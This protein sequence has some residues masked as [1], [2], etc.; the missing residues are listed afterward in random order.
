MELYKK[1]VAKFLLSSEVIYVIPPYQRA[2]SWG[3][4]RWQGLA[5]DVL[6]KY[7]SPD[8]KHWIGIVVTAKSEMNI[9]RVDYTRRQYDLIDGQQRLITLRVWTQ[10]LLDHA[11]ERGE[12]LDEESLPFAQI[13]VQEI[14]KRDFEDV[15]GANNP[16]RQKWRTYGPDET[17][18]MHCYTYF[19]WILWLGSNA[20][21]KTEP[22]P[23][24]KKGRSQSEQNLTVEQQWQSTLDKRSRM[25]EEDESEVWIVQRGEQIPVAD[26]LKATLEYLNVFE[27]EREDSVD[28]EP[29]EIFEAL[30]GKRTQLDQF[31]H[32]KTFIFANVKDLES[33]YSLYEDDWKEFEIALERHTRKMRGAI[34]GDTFLY[35]YLISVGE[36]RYQSISMNRTA[37][38][39]TRYF[40]NRAS[41]SA[42]EI[43]RNDFLKSMRAWIA[44][45]RFGEELTI[46]GVSFPL[47]RDS[48]RSLHMINALS[49]GPVTPLLMRIISN[50][51]DGNCNENELNR[52]LHAV[53]AFVGRL[54]MSR[55]PLSPLRAELMNFMSEIELST[56][57]TVIIE[58]LKDIAPSDEK[59]R[60]ALLAYSLES[61]ARYRESANIGAET[62]NG[63]LRSRQILAIFQAIEAKRS[64][65]MRH[66][67][68]ET[69]DNEKFTIEHIYP[70][71]PD[72]WTRDV[73]SWGVS[74]QLLERRTHVIGNLGVIPS[75]LNS[76]LQNAPL[77]R[78][79]EIFQ[80]PESDFPPLKVNEYWTR[81]SQTK[82]KPDDI[83]RRSEQL[84]A[85]ALEY[86]TID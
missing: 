42:I 76:Q 8:K 82:W 12:R 39:F 6:N 64:G 78:K 1:T 22:E 72:E 30:N 2:Y 5:N 80:N 69:T 55:V 41:G 48:K 19:R 47:T 31:D 24:P 10:A 38:S 16:W 40:K 53:E 56:S 29:V 73:R 9:G 26:L 62:A 44:V 58:K 67:L 14:D 79:R 45:N 18:I 61:E 32:V 59:I 17:G 85:S 68:L 3:R 34:K 21:W 57:P 15:T 84:V 25:Q 33:R 35:D 28:E 77:S 81:E 74:G 63:G 13:R 70:K 75:R 54:V 4:D 11:K 86:W 20:I 71:Q 36:T 60:E 52:Q 43:A 83:D 66:N 49:Q 65:P 46:N 7:T 27:L 51:F 50:Y 37:A 23:L